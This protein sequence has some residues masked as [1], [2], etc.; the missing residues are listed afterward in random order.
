[1]KLPKHRWLIIARNFRRELRFWIVQQGT[2]LRL[3]QKMIWLLVPRQLKFVTARQKSVPA[4][5]FVQFMASIILLVAVSAAISDYGQ[6]PVPPLIFVL[7]AGS[8]GAVM[9]EV[10]DV[11]RPEGILYLRETIAGAAT[12]LA[13]YVLLIAQLVEG[14][15]FP[16][17]TVGDHWLIQSSDGFRHLVKVTPQSYGD[18]AK[19]CIWAFIGGLS[20]QS[21]V[22][23]FSRFSRKLFS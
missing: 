12:G 14:G 17:F 3:A 23:G 11:K 21:V 6:K 16:K 22:R 15:I 10:R 7:A 18:A 13:V 1:M 4:S 2:A 19:C 8:L 9:R 5:R 20:S